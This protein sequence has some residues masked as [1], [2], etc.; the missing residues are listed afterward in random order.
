DYEFTEKFI[1]GNARLCFE[2]VHEDDD[3][4]DDDDETG[5]EEV[6]EYSSCYHTMKHS[7]SMDDVEMTIEPHHHPNLD[8]NPHPRLR[9]NKIMYLMMLRCF[10]TLT[11]LFLNNFI[12]SPKLDTQS[13]PVKHRSTLAEQEVLKYYDQNKGNLVVKNFICLY[14]LSD[15]LYTTS[16]SK[17][18]SH[19]KK[20]LE[21]LNNLFR[22]YVD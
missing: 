21:T 13:R 15:T 22:S 2:N 18:L 4:E 12:N 16:S 17:C 20:S 1:V 7:P 8:Q 6:I 11:T 19:M 5:E 9:R 10:Q 3:D 14:K